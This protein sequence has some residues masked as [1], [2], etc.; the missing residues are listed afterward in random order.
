M[1]AEWLN[2]PLKQC[3]CHSDYGSERY[4]EAKC[5]FSALLLCDREQL[6]EWKK[7]ASLYLC[8]TAFFCTTLRW[9]L[10]RFCRAGFVVVLQLHFQSSSSHAAP[11]LFHQMRVSR[12]SV[13]SVTI[14]QFLIGEFPQEGNGRK[15]GHKG[16]MPVAQPMA[17]PRCCS[18]CRTDSHPQQQP[19]AGKEHGVPKPF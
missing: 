11:G 4:W 8:L 9:S 18:G 17:G 15:T 12:Q 14:P 13:K 2:N 16:D 7:P 19:C 1:V 6:R 10:L 5:S 3:V